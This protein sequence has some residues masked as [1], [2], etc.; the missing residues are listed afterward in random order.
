MAVDLTP[1]K[2]RVANLEKAALAAIGVTADAIPYFRH[3]QET[4]PYFV[5][6][7][8]QFGIEADSQDFDTYNPPI[9]MRLV[10]G[11]ITNGYKGESDAKLDAWVPQIIEYFNERE[12]LI[13]DTYTTEIDYLESAR[14]TNCTF[15]REF[16][17]GGI[18]GFQ[19]G[20]EFTLRLEFQSDIIQ[21]RD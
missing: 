5:N 12:L 8:D 15:Y 3:T 20:C 10:I 18:G 14:I 2:E 17:H 21:V 19:V 1:V 11:H 13:D 4:F 16:Q 6:R 9:I 7:F